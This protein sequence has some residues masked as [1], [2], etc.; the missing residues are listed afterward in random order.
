M[1]TQ[2]ADAALAR[3]AGRRSPLRLFVPGRIEVLGKHTDYAGGRSLTCAAERGF[4]VSYVPRDD[5][6]L[7][8]VDA[9]DGRQVEFRVEAALCPE[10]GHWS[11]YPMTVARRLARN[12]GPLARGADVAFYS[13]LPKAAG[14]STS[15]ALITAVFLVLAEVNELAAATSFHRRDPGHLPPGRLPGVHRERQRVR[16]ARWRPGRGH[17]RRQRGPHRD[18]I[19]PGRPADMVS[20]SPRDAGGAYRPQSRLCVRGG[21]QRDRGGEDRRRA[22]EIQP[23]LSACRRT[24]G[25]GSWSAR[26]S[27]GAWPARNARRDHR[28]L[29]GRHRRTFGR[30]RATLAADASSTSSSKTGLCCPLPSTRWRQAGSPSSACSSI[31]HSARQRTCWAI[32]CPRRSP[33]RDWRARAAR[34]PRRRLG[35]DSAAACGRW[36]TRVGPRS[37]LISG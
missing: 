28:C 2:R 6:V 29:A 21:G 10:V 30:V 24:R 17:G 35:P 36:W 26:T 5:D 3:L 34:M 32:R 4:S 14:L 1:R 23:C 9:Q 19:E 22:R 20:I 11:N 13:T 15:S 37:L 18:R 16:C 12:F 31:A 25:S 7:R 8:L 33:W 27:G